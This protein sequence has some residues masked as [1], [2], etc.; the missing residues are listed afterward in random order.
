MESVT[1]KKALDTRPISGSG[2][3]MPSRC[4][5][6]VTPKEEAVSERGAEEEERAAEPLVVAVNVADE[7][8]EA[9][10]DTARA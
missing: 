9:E 10:L 7:E 4:E 6:W 5:M 8:E 2:R 3:A 1:A